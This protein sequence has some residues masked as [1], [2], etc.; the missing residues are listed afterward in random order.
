MLRLLAM[1]NPEGENDTDK[2]ENIECEQE[3]GRHVD[4]RDVSDW[5]ILG[6]V[7]YIQQNLRESIPH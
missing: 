1:N 4:D 3:C 7:S 6:D 2:C 5:V